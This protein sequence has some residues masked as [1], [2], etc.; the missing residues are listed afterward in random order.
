MIFKKDKD[1][2]QIFNYNNN[3]LNIVN[4]YKYLGLVITLKM[5]HLQK[6]NNYCQIEP[7]K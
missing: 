3:A 7:R 5:D 4:S 2:N 1:P 6:L